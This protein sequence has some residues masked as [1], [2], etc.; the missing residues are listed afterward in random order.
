[1]LRSFVA[2]EIFELQVGDDAAEAGRI[3][4][5]LCRII[6]KR[7]GEETVLM[8]MSHTIE[9]FTAQYQYRT[10]QMYPSSMSSLACSNHRP[11]NLDAK[12]LLG[13]W[14]TRVLRRTAMMVPPTL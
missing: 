5:I 9:T 4:V 14:R 8:S 11:E 13:A 12:A 7:R 2:K 10:R 6:V 3:L 1:M